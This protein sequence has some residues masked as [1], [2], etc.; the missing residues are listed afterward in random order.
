[1]K[2]ILAMVG[3]ILLCVSSAAYG[4]SRLY[5][6]V[7]A[8]PYIE[9]HTGPGV[10][11]PI[12]NVEDRG[13]T[14][15]VIKRHTDWFRVQTENGK[16]GWVA[17]DQLERT[18]Q[19]DGTPT[20]IKNLSRDDYLSRRWETGLQI[21]DFGGANT[22][23]G[24]GG[25]H[26]TEH[27]SAEL[28][29]SQI[30]GDF[31][32]G[33][34]VNVNIVHQPFPAWIVSPYF[35]LGTGVLHIEPKATLVQAQDRTDQEAHAGFGIRSHISRQFILRAEYKSYVVFTSTDENEDVNQWTAGFS[36]YF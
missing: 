19:T 11:Y 32:E 16:R 5:K 22:I 9:M 6:V 29:A 20:Q 23:S 3:V 4:K 12:F 18:L 13:Q 14:I 31:S 36:F 25:F 35:T 28:W 21:G 7:I 10:G 2:N 1:M 15:E 30:T 27:L 17:A 8:D 33:W 24:Y 26:F 34:M